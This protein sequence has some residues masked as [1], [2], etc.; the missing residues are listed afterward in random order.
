MSDCGHR[1]DIDNAGGADLRWF[2][3]EKVDTSKLQMIG[4]GY[5]MKEKP[6]VRH[7]TREDYRRKRIRDAKADL[8]VYIEE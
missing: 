3:R 7:H 2:K 5:T 1:T 8:E 6:V 4:I